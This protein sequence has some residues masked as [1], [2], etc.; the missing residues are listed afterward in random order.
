[1]KISKIL[2]VDNDET[3][4]KAIEELLIT[5]GYS[6]NSVTS[7]QKGIEEYKTGARI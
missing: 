4:L 3:F 1:M 6:T 2:I 5:L 7:G